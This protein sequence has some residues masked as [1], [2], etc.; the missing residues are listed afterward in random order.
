MKIKK[1]VGKVMLGSL[2]VLIFVVTGELIGYLEAA[3][4]WSTSIFIYGFFDIALRITIE[5]KE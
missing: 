4:L 5:G 3:A 2:A 1:W